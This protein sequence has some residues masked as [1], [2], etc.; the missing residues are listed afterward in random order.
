MKN[1]FIQNILPTNTDI[2][3]YYLALNDNK[4]LDRGILC[5]QNFIKFFYCYR[6]P[7]YSADKFIGILSECSNEMCQFFQVQ[8]HS[9]R[10]AST[11][12][13]TDRELWIIS[14]HDYWK[15]KHMYDKLKEAYISTLDYINRGY[16]F[17]DT[18]DAS[19][20]K[21]VDTPFRLSGF[22]ESGG[23]RNI[24]N[25]FELDSDVPLYGPVHMSEELIANSINNFK[26]VNYYP[27]I[28]QNRQTKLIEKSESIEI[29][30][31]LRCL[32]Y[33]IETFSVNNNKPDITN[34]SDA[35]I[36][37][38]VSL[39]SPVDSKPLKKWCLTWGEFS[40]DM[41]PTSEVKGK[42]YYEVYGEH[43]DEPIRAS[44]G[45]IDCSKLN[46]TNQNEDL[47]M[48][49]VSN[50]EEG[51]LKDFI[52]LLV[53]IQPQFTIGFNNFGFDDRVVYHRCCKYGLGTLI[54]SAFDW[55]IFNTM[56][57][58]ASEKMGIGKYTKSQFG[59]VNIKMDG[60]MA[61]DFTS[62]ISGFN[63]TL[64]IQQLIVAGDSKRFKQRKSLKYM[65]AY[66]G[67]KNP[68]TNG[69]I[70][71]YDYDYLTMHN[72]RA[73]N[74]HNYDM[75]RY[76]AQDAMVT[77]LLLIKVSKIIDLIARAQLVHCN[78][79][80]AAYSGASRQVLNNSRYEHYIDGFL[81]QDAIIKDIR[82]YQCPM[83]K[84]WDKRTVVGGMVKNYAPGKHIGVAALD[85]ASMYPAQKEASNIDTSARIPADVMEPA[86]QKFI[87]KNNDQYNEFGFRVVGMWNEAD[88]YTQGIMK[89]R[90][91]IV[92]EV[93]D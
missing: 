66:Y 59:K 61:Y 81:L 30:P 88:M 72:N 16:I 7:G 70:S 34:Y 1:C 82:E 64:D 49:V 10:D 8:P 41:Q 6:F 50:D 63:I 21:N 44:D 32:V 85:F 22:L 56:P 71:K 26:V 74:I 65:L 42:K 37:I 69:E 48:Y 58:Q 57:A 19:Y 52:R 5:V 77:G 28:A 14:S 47:T 31:A 12:S 73:A 67:I 62:F 38:G 18:I 36:A 2:Y 86:I 4:Q 3:I 90:R 78:M 45:F 33:D 76:C 53:D 40:S 91:M 11:F 55:N 29:Y 9:F 84:F 75:C 54:I 93:P 60:K 13:F 27:T 25:M 80:D 43:L 24:V 35:I 46:R 20:L 87:N 39:F 83:K 51:M 15:L 89:N 68:Y 23:F 17:L 92:I 79:R